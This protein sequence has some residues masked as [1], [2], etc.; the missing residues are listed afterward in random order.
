[1]RAQEKIPRTFELGF[2]R[3]EDFSLAVRV[4]KATA[5][6]QAGKGVGRQGTGVLSSGLQ[7][8]G[9]MVRGGLDLWGC[10]P[11]LSRVL[12]VDRS[13]QRS[14]LGLACHHREP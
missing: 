10:G 9:G 5:G 6:T 2:E 7:K 14:S 11:S 4:N 3:E 13:N 12:P 8:T 1:M